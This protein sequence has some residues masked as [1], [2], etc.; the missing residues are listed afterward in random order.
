MDWSVGRGRERQMENNQSNYLGYLYGLVYYFCF[1][2][3]I[4]ILHNEN[5]YLCVKDWVLS[6][7]C[8]LLS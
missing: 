7:N 3:L 2:F 8:Y 4:R 5:F 1:P 6:C